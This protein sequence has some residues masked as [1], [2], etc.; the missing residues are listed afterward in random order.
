VKTLEELDKEFLEK[1]GQQ[2]K[3]EPAL[4]LTLPESAPAK[5][6]AS[7]PVYAVPEYTAPR[8]A[9]PAPETG[10]AADKE[11]KRRPL[12]IAADVLFYTALLAVLVIV[13]IFG[14]QSGR[15]VFGYSFFT[16]LSSSMQREIPM[17]SLVIVKEI[18]A[19]EIKAGDDITFL[20]D[21]D[22]IVTH[23]VQRI[24]ENYEGSG[25]RGFETQGLEN[26]MPDEEIVYAAN[27]MGKV[28]HHID[29]LGDTLVWFRNHWILGAG[30]LAGL[31]VLYSSLKVLF[32]GDG[33]K[34][35][36]KTAGT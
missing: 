19:D 18:T 33:K 22:T 3:D 14:V 9:A 30:M 27:V 31:V 17:G 12:A 6:G 21:K 25:A 1:S 13:P 35:K 15:N 36:R 20:R 26:P 29:D 10:D 4:R 2:E 23:R 8:Y 34:K 7:P 32:S 16:V 28:V 11:R 5:D 24:F